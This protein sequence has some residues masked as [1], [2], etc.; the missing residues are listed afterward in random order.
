MLLL[1]TLQALATR[2]SLY[3]MRDQTQ[4]IITQLQGHIP[5]PHNVL[6]Y[7]QLVWK[8]RQPGT[9]RGTFPA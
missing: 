8:V 6:L 4:A 1:M 9:S 3:S 2:F 5:D 7:E